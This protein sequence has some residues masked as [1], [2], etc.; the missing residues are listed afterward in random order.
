MGQEE[1][2]SLSWSFQRE[3]RYNQ[4]N[5]DNLVFL[6][7]MMEINFLK[8]ILYRKMFR[9]YRAWDTGYMG[10]ASDSFD[11]KI[12]EE[13]D[14]SIPKILVEIT[15]WIGMLKTVPNIKPREDFFEDICAIKDDVDWGNSEID[16]IY[17]ELLKVTEEYRLI[18]SEVHNEST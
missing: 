9:I 8:F 14:E 11:L 6:K 16:K 5:T 10:N 4:L 15:K 3:V 2:E 13:W 7:T 18:I 12:I 1:Q 17:E